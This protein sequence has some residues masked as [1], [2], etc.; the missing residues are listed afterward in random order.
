MLVALSRLLRQTCTIL[1]VA[2]VVRFLFLDIISVTTQP[3]VGT[4]LLGGTVPL[5]GGPTSP[6]GQNIPPALAQY[7]NQLMQKFPQNAGGQ[8]SCPYYGPT[9]S[10]C[11]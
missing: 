6:L 4:Q 8:A 3:M 1:L 11:D 2:R 5:I 10:R 9:I 7:W